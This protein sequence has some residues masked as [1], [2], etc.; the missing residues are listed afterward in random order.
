MVSGTGGSTGSTS[1]KPRPRRDKFAPKRDQRVLQSLMMQGL[2]AAA[3][4][5]MAFFARHEPK[6]MGLYLV[7][8][9]IPVAWAGV[10]WTSHRKVERSRQ[11]GSWSPEWERAQ[12]RRAMGVLGAVFFVWVLVVALVALYV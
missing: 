3:L 11:D 9:A 6:T 4:V 12:T 7:S 8:L 2:L 1:P 5:L 10:A